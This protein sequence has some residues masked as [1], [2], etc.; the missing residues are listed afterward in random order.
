M[1]STAA[2]TATPTPSEGSQ[3]QGVVPAEFIGEWRGLLTQPDGGFLKNGPQRYTIT[4]TI[5]QGSIGDYIAEAEYPEL[6]CKTSWRL[7]ETSSDSIKVDEIVSEIHA[8]SCIDVP[9][10]LT[11]KSGGIDYVVENPEVTGHLKH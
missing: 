11:A 6:S 7:Y 2:P 10:K 4:A 1:D 3:P 9:I 5:K 8:G